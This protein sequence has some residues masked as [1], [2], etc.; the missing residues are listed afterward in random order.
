MCHLKSKSYICYSD[1]AKWLHPPSLKMHHQVHFL[2]MCTNKCKKMIYT[3]KIRPLLELNGFKSPAMA[4]DGPWEPASGRAGLVLESSWT[5]PPPAARG[6]RTQAQ[7]RGGSR[8]S[9]S[10]HGAGQRRARAGDFHSVL[11]PSAPSYQKLRFLA[12]KSTVKVSH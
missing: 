7:A 8:C 5:A 12:R 2:N 10:R 11:N 1:N 6:R 4:G 3:R 9:Q